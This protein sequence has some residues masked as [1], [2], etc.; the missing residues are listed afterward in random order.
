MIFVYAF[1]ILSL[2][3]IQFF[4]KLFDVNKD[5]LVSSFLWSLCDKFISINLLDILLDIFQTSL[6]I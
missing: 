4:Q 5:Y 6:F 1:S 2:V 3:F